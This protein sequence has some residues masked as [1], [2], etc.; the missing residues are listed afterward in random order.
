MK[1]PE[2]KCERATKPDRYRTRIANSLLLLEPVLLAANPTASPKKAQHP[3]GHHNHDHP[4][5]II[6]VARM[7]FGHVLKVHP[8]HAGNERQGQHDCRENRQDLH[9]LV[10]PVGN[11]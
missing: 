5:S 3:E 11:H 4:D 6:A 10:Q 8:I 1:A 7:K 2:G 9:D